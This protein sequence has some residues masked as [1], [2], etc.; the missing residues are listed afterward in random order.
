MRCCPLLILSMVDSP[1]KMVIR[2]GVSYTRNF[3][4]SVWLNKKK[5]LLLMK[6][7]EIELMLDVLISITDMAFEDYFSFYSVI[8]LNKPCL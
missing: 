2:I 4:R 5:S 8:S 1:P 7:F 6:M 3:M